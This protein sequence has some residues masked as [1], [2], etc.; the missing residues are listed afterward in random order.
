MAKKGPNRPKQRTILQNGL[1]LVQYQDR[2]DE[3]KLSGYDVR[4]SLSELTNWGGEDGG[5][6]MY[7]KV[8][9]LKATNRRLPVTQGNDLVCVP[10]DTVQ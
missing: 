5:A 1:W 2:P 4:F 6:D 9:N 7:F 10:W 3:F 8:I